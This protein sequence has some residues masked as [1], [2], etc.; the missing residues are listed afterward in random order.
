[1]TQDHILKLLRLIRH[2]DAK[3]PKIRVGALQDGGY[4]IN[5][6]F[7]GIDGVVSIGIGG[8]VSFDLFFA[9]RGL[10]V[11]QYDQTVDGPPVKH[12]N[13]I[14]RKLAWAAEDGP[15]ARS[16]GSIIKENELADCHDLILKFDT[17]GAEWQA[18]DSIDGNLLDK[19]R[20]ITAEFHD[21][22]KLENPTVFAQMSR[23]FSLI[24]QTHVATHIHANNTSRVALVFGVPLPDLLEISFLRRDRS[25]FTPSS[26]PIP[27]IF[28]RPNIPNRPDIVL[29]PFGG[30]G[31]DL[32]PIAPSIR[33]P[34]APAAA[35]Q[36]KTTEPVK[37][38]PVFNIPDHLV[39]GYTMNGSVPVH[40]Y[41]LY[42]DF[43]SGELHWRNEDYQKFLLSARECIDAEKGFS[44]PSDPFLIRLLK[45]H[46]IEGQS[47]LMIGS[48]RPYFEAMVV[49]FGGKPTTVEY[50]R[51]NHN[52]EGLKT[53]TVEELE[54]SDL[55]FD[56]ALS[57]SAIEHSG[58]GRYGDVL[59][60]EADFKAMDAYRRH[61]KPGGLLFL[62]VP[63][64][65]DALVWNA[66]RIYGAGRLPRLLRGW[67][68]VDS[69][70]YDDA[71]MTKGG[72]GFYDQPAFLLRNV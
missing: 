72:L 55:Q 27:S 6:D 7:D 25:Q 14:F 43:G 39:R 65:R 54:A 62:Q 19:F 37:R 5:R 38:G 48:E 58:L 59:D 1:M 64:G 45:R 57:I 20:I 23:V 67:E 60:P 50:R 71:L 12:Q 53:F 44:Y 9:E 26:E 56:C 11:F 46:S 34:A 24:N 17:E 49:Q 69:E 15:A 4:V 18:F 29:T 66:H 3:I 30:D 47:V 2:H 31:A 35:P 8:E 10:K 41:F 42:G 32:A 51:I 22:C 63:V 28:D 61:L 68:R 70:G 13:F 16:L 52:I 21:F 36:E 40:V 33:P